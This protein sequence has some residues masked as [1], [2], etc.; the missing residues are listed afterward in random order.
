[1][2]DEDFKRARKLSVLDDWSEDQADEAQRLLGVLLAE[3]QRL[4]V[5]SPRTDDEI[6]GTL[7]RRRAKARGA[8]GNNA[9]LAVPKEQS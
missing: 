9:S 3:V 6:L 4:N 8:Q 1:V 7:M 2:T 5:L